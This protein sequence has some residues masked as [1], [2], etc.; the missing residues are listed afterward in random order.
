MSIPPGEKVLSEDEI[1]SKFD[2]FGK[3]VI[4]NERRNID[5]AWERRKRKEQQILQRNKDTVQIDQYPSDKYVIKAGHFRCVLSDERLYQALR[6]LPENWRG[7]LI[8]QFWRSWNDY[9][10]AAHYG[11]SD[12]AIRKWRK[13]AYD[14]ITAFYESR[15]P[16]EIDSRNHPRGHE[17]KPASD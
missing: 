10:I 17:G 13:K 14:R 16:D 1:L 4:R 8:A 6:A 9:R 2:P 15:Y 7:I 11:V 5:R 3:K 12:R